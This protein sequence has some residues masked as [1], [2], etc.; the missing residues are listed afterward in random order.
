MRTTEITVSV[1]EAAAAAATS[2]PPLIDLQHI[3]DALLCVLL[4]AFEGL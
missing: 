4:L 3:D 2:V 1:A